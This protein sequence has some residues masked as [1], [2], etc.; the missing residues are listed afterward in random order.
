M[1]GTRLWKRLVAGWMVMVITLVFSCVRGKA[2]E[3]T[4]TY[5]KD[6]KLYIDENKDPS[7]VKDWFEKNNYTMIEGN[8]NEDASGNLKQEVGVY[9][10]Y[11][12][13]TNAKEAV[14][15]IA[16]MNERG[17]YSVGEYERILKEQK[18]M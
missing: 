8:L 17:N 16:V 5:I 13:T 12:T 18:K 11:S 7:A 15:D 2:A 3:K 14:T 9:L 1:T 6:F 4:T 10:G